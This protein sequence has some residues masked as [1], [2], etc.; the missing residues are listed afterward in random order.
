MAASIAGWIEFVLLRRTLN[1]RIGETGLPLSLTVRLWGAAFAAAALA[2]AIK[3]ALAD[4]HPIAEAA[5]V[6]VP[7]GITFVG[8]TLL[9]GVAEARSVFARLR[10]K[11]K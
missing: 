9:L 8:L 4:T 11:H 6:L 10:R 2:W 5:F 1:K 3:L 7:F